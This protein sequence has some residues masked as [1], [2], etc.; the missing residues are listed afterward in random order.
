MPLPDRIGGLPTWGV[1]AALGGAAIVGYF[2][3]FRNSSSTASTANGPQTPTNTGAATNPA[4]YSAS[5][6]AQNQQ[7][8]VLTDYAAQQSAGIAGLGAASS[9]LADQ[10]AGVGTQVTDVRQAEGGLGTQLNS[11]GGQKANWAA[12][13]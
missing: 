2:I 11:L 9:G 3:F 5:I 10:L 7:L 6:G 4:D 12:Y 1:V 13:G 8:A